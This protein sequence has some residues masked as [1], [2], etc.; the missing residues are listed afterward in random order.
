MTYILLLVHPY[1]L[2]YKWIPDLGL[3]FQAVDV[4][5]LSTIPDLFVPLLLEI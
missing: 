5:S 2:T 3:N 4:M 1:N